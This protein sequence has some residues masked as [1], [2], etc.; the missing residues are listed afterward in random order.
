MKHIKLNDRCEFPLS[1][2]VEP[3]TRDGLARQE[4]GAAS[5]LIQLSGVEMETGTKIEPKHPLE[6]Y[7]YE[8]AGIVVHLGTAGLFPSCRC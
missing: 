3:F 2:N 6:Y 7:E 5:I 4:A 1:L 8:L